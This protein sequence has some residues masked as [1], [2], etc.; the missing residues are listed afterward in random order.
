[1]GVQGVQEDEEEEDEEEEEMRARDLLAPLDDIYRFYKSGGVDVN[2]SF[3][4]G[5]TLPKVRGEGKNRREEKGKRRRGE[6]S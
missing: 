2:I 5:A 3:F 6:G 1:M 4:T